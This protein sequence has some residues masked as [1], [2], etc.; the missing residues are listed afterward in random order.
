MELPV[1]STIKKSDRVTIKNEITLRVSDYYQKKFASDEAYVFEEHDGE[2]YP[3]PRVLIR[4]NHDKWYVTILKTNETVDV[5]TRLKAEFV[6]L[7]FIE[8]VRHK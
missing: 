8:S 5:N 4:R 1:T 3:S 2:S 7:S 6:G